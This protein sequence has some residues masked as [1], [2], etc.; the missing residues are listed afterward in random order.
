M[1]A[2][3]TR[4][5][6]PRFRTPTTTPCG[7]ATRRWRRE[8]PEFPRRIASRKR[9]GAAP[10]EKFAKVRA[11]GAD[12]VARQCVRRRGR[13]RIRRAGAAVSCAGPSGRFGFTAEPK[14]DGLSCSLRYEDGKLVERRHARRRREGEDVT[15]NVRTIARHPAQTDG[16]D[17]AGDS[18]SARRSLHGARP[19]SR[20]STP[21]GRGRR[22]DLR[23]PA[24]RRGGL[25]APAGFDDHRRRPLR[26][27]A[28]AWG[29][30]SALPGRYAGRHDRSV[31][32]RWGFP[33][34]PLAVLC[35]TPRSDAGLLSRHRGA[36]RDPRL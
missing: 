31:R 17:C 9:V 18:G 36:A 29:E 33:T 30:V 11:R 8:F 4:T 1:T 20:P 5:T 21:A 7:G 22:Q 14:I 6:R 10:A 16:A 26:F 15:A 2:P 25:A 13:A 34:N 23:Q 27:F 12:A 3:I 24:Q 19:I 32:R 28:Y 35:E